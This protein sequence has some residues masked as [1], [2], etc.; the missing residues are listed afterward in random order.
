MNK[1]KWTT[2]IFLLLITV[3]MF[4]TGC[5]FGSGSSSTTKEEFGKLE[6]YVASQ[7]EVENYLKAPATADF[8]VFEDTFVYQVDDKNFNIRAW[9]DSE[10]SFGAMIR[11]TYTCKVEYLGNDK[12]RV[13]DINFEE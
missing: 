3:S 8:P 7:L 9:V 4:V 11:T 10:N 12:Y 1:C 2:T 5:C 6:A 13:Y